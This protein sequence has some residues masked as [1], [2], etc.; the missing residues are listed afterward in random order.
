MKYL[1]AIASQQLRQEQNLP[2]NIQPLWTDIV[3]RVEL[4]QRQ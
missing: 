4:L 3:K 2:Y 1:F